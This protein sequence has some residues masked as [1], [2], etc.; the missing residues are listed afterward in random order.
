M[1]VHFSLV[2][3]SCRRVAYAANRKT[4][5]PANLVVF[6]WRQESIS[7]LEVSGGGKLERG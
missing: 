7:W 1:E 2:W 4:H 3:P 6:V 5:I